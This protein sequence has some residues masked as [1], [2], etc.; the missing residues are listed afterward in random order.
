MTD[1]FGSSLSLGRTVTVYCN[2]EFGAGKGK[3]LFR[4]NKCGRFRLRW[5]TAVMHVGYGWSTDD[6]MHAASVKCNMSPP[7]TMAYNADG[8]VIDDVRG[9]GCS[10]A[11]GRAPRHSRRRWAR[12]ASRAVVRARLQVQCVDNGEILFLAHGEPFRPPPAAAGGGASGGR[13]VGGYAVGRSLGSGG[14]GSVK[15]GTH[16]VTGELV[17]LK[18]LRKSDMGSTS[19][20]ERVVTEVQCLTELVHPHI[21]KLLRV[22]NEPSHVVLVLEYADRGDLRAFVEAQPGRV[23]A[24]ELARHVFMQIVGAWA[25]LHSVYYMHVIVLYSVGRAVRG[26]AACAPRASVAPAIS[27]AQAPWASRTRDTSATGT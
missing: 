10:D 11:G 18:F 22:L 1:D 16:T 14:F 12:A 27:R 21:I 3:G 8:L 13:V 24:P 5:R 15:L 20:V 9:A 4:T 26:R 2:G 6:F 17:A 23:C 7:A 25:L 19:A